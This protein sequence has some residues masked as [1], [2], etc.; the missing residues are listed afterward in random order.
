MQELEY[1]KGYQYAHDTEEK[2]TRMQCLPDSLKERRYYLPT[3]Q[4]KEAAVKER[5]DEILNWKHQGEEK[6]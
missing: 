5:M 1:G 6:Q 2:L 4:G 3:E